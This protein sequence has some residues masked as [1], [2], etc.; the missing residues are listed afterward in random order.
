MTMHL[1]SR[2]FNKKVYFSF[3]FYLIT[4]II[5]ELFGDIVSSK[6][7]RKGYVRHYSN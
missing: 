2:L 4:Y 1:T 6:V 3:D 5:Y 7:M